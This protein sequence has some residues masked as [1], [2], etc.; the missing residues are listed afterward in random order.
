MHSWIHFYG[1]QLLAA[2]RAA[3]LSAADLKQIRSRVSAWL[4]FR[5]EVDKAWESQYRDLKAI[6]EQ[7]REKLK[8]R[9]VEAEKDI[10]P[11]EGRFGLISEERG[12]LRSAE[13][14]RSGAERVLELG[15]WLEN[16]SSE[17]LER[18]RDGR[19]QAQKNLARRLD[20]ERTQ[21]PLTV[22]ERE[23]NVAAVKKAHDR[24]GALLLRDKAGTFKPK[25]SRY[26]IGELLLYD[27]EFAKFK[28]GKQ[29]LA[30]DLKL[31]KSKHATLTRY[32]SLTFP[33]KNC[34]KELTSQDKSEIQWIE[35]AFD[36]LKDGLKPTDPCC[37]KIKEG[38]RTRTVRFTPRAI[39]DFLAFHQAREYSGVAIRISAEL[40]SSLPVGPLPEFM[41][42]D[43]PRFENLFS[44]RTSDPLSGTEKSHWAAS[45]I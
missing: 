32:D 43:P 6:D 26:D 18:I 1:R 9:I 44:S 30:S 28:S 19:N 14:V 31:Y 42:K 41:K 24:L 20:M 16:A 21:S 17:Q 4:D 27:V 22:D 11:L 10:Q 39:R 45:G 37:A 25:E 5:A 12:L 23:E 3:S 7:A 29:L 34:L 36:A 15:A 35:A 33:D 38:V 8:A 2:N 40:V 13:I